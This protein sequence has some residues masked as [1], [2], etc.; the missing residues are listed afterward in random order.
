MRK[1][2]EL[3]EPT[4]RELLQLIQQQ[5]ERYN[6]RHKELMATQHH[7]MKQQEDRHKE[8]MATQNTIL[9]TQTELMSALAL[10][11]Q[12]MNGKLDVLIAANAKSRA[13]SI[14]SRRSAS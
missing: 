10:Q 8:L 6:D 11:F 3:T 14:S 7:L 4:T 1:M 5:G 9:A 13:K 2:T 12:V